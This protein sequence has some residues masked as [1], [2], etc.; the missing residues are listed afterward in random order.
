MRCLGARGSSATTLGDEDG[1]KQQ[2]IQALL[3]L[4]LLQIMTVVAGRNNHFEHVALAKD[5]SSRA[6]FYQCE[7]H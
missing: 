5:E 6:S 3:Y 1:A 2:R 4:T 7:L